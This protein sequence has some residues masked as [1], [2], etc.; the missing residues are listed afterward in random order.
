MIVIWKGWGIGIVLLGVLAGAALFAML[1]GAL[2]SSYMASHAWPAV[3]ST[4]GSG[5]CM[6]FLGLTEKGRQSSVYFI[7][8]VA[9]GGLVLVLGPLI[10]GATRS[11]DLRAGAKAAAA[12]PAPPAVTVAGSAAKPSEVTVYASEE[13]SEW[14]KRTW[15]SFSQDG[16]ATL[17]Q[18]STGSTC[19]VECSVNDKRVWFQDGCL[20]EVKDV[21][22]VSNDCERVVVIFP[23]PLRGSGWQRQTVASVFDRSRKA[24]DVA[25][26]TVVK[27]SRR[28]LIAQ[29]WASGLC[30]DASAPAPRYAPDG[31]AVE[32]T[33]IDGVPNRIPLT[34]PQALAA[35]RARK[36][37]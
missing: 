5:L 29:C 25:A 15:N 13:L 6:I 8:V 4:M 24:W 14:D 35:K 3:V 30:G 9:W 17:V 34:R 36:G 23:V 26:G 21:R 22:F 12:A 27:D 2:G 19:Q 20:G 11:A 33:S 7:P 37:R 16:H 28:A 1:G 10:A 32:F 18:N 31:T